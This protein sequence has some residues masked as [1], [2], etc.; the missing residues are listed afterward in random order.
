MIKDS[1]SILENHNFVLS[2]LPSKELKI[3]YYAPNHY[4]H[5]ID[6]FLTLHYSASQT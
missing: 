4:E 6:Q 2:D 1:I 3:V 5:L